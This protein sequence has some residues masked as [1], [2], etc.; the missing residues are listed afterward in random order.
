MDTTALAG[1]TGILEVPVRSAAPVFDL[2]AKLRAEKDMDGAGIIRR[3]VDKATPIGDPAEGLVDYVASDETL[4]CYAEIVR[5]AG[6]KFSDFDHNP[7][8]IDSHRRQ[9]ISD[10][11]GAVVSHS[12]QAGPNGRPQLVER[13]K[14]AVAPE[15]GNDLAQ[16][17]YKMTAAGFLRAVSVGFSPTKLVWRGFSAPADWDAAVAL[18]NLST[19]DAANVEVIYLEQEQRE[20][21]ACILGANG[22]ALAKEFGEVVRAH[23]AGAITD[24]DLEALER[25]EAKRISGQSPTPKTRHINRTADQDAKELGEFRTKTGEA[26]KSLEEAAKDKATKDEVETLSGKVVALQRSII[27]GAGAPESAEKQTAD[28][29]GQIAK[30]YPEACKAVAAIF[31]AVKGRGAAAVDLCPEGGNGVQMGAAVT[32]TK[33][34]GEANASAA[35]LLNPEQTLD[36]YDLLLSYGA[37]RDLDVGAMILADF[38]EAVAYRMDYSCFLGDGTNDVN[39]IN[40]GILGIINAGTVVTAGAGGTTVAAMKYQDVLA[41]QTGAAQAIY[42]RNPVWWMNP[43]ILGAFLGI[44]DQNGRP[45]FQQ[46]LDAPKYGAIGNINGFPVKLTNVL[47]AVN[48]AGA[49]IAIF[50]DGKAFAVGLRQDFSFGFSDDVRYTSNQRV[51]RGLMR[52]TG[53]IKNPLALRILKLSAQ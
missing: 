42:G 38:A 5:V 32:V 53:G 51:F 19:T 43:L 36:I 50:G 11:L 14:W 37:F 41:V 28:L 8:F 27:T 47:P 23:Q 3:A 2:A 18:L 22:N 6:W 48:A 16:F 24:Q 25:F 7:A 33:A 20:L 40:G 9:S 17:G 21:S 13:V 31:V 4:D 39:G 34:E 30:R 45:L 12:V 29:A 15:V 35:A 26:L 46:A 44:M 49:P 10:C 52:G 1:L